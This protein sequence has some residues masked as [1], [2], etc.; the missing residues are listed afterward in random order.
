MKQWDSLVNLPKTI[1][2]FNTVKMLGVVTWG[3]PKVQL[4][5][6]IKPYTFIVDRAVALKAAI[7]FEVKKDISYKRTP[8]FCQHDHPNTKADFIF[9]YL[10]WLKVTLCIQKV[11]VPRGLSSCPYIMKLP[12][13]KKVT[14]VTI[15][16]ITSDDVKCQLCLSHLQSHNRRDSYLCLLQTNFRGRISHSRFP[17]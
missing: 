3:T 16:N 13:G 1:S 15:K 17:T 6:N 4:F 11:H 10:W 7:T 8:L 2:I 12:W 5:I 9:H 14:N